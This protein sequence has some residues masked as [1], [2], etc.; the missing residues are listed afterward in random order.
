MK[1]EYVSYRN[2]SEKTGLSE[3]AL[4]KLRIR[5]IVRSSIAGFANPMPVICIDDVLMWIEQVKFVPAPKI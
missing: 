4:H 1:P 3:I 2:A 5:G